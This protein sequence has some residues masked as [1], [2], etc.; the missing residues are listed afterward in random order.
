[1]NAFEWDLYMSKSL[2]F[3]GDFITRQ[4]RSIS[5][6]AVTQ[7]GQFGPEI[8]SMCSGRR[9]RIPCLKMAGVLFGR[10]YLT[11]EYHHTVSVAEI[12]RIHILRTTG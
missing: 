11:K 4:C 6:V 12:F 1:V 10:R 2:L 7:A 8:S 3:H 9:L 5:S